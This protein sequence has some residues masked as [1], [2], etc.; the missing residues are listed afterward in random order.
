MPLKN[1]P[2]NRVL[3]LAVSP[4][5][6]DHDSLSALFSHSNWELR[7]ATNIREA[8]DCL[9]HEAI[10]VVICE[11]D[12]KDG[13]AWRDLLEALSDRTEPPHL[14]VT[15]SFA[16]DFLWA[17]ALNLG[18]YDVLPKPFQST[19]VFRVLSLAWRN[20]HDRMRNREYLAKLAVA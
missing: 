9:D 8:L 16:D 11:R 13:T 6:E 12:L 7:W 5:K 14:I 10:P 20:W 19:E 1:L 4:F 2:Q 3:V 17:E 15:S 18:C